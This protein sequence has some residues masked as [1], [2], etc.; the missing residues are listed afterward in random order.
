MKTYGVMDIVYIHVLLTSA[1]VG[2]EWSA[3]RPG[4][5]NSGKRVYS[6]HWIRRWVDPRAGLHDVEKRKFLTLQGLEMRLLSRRARSQ[7]LYRLS[8]PGSLL[9]TD[10][11]LILVTTQMT[12]S[13]LSRKASNRE[14]S[15][16]GCNAVWFGT[17]NPALQMQFVDVT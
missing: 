6:T 12:S 7:S 13:V 4:R 10:T 16:L 9:T 1:L 14:N 5:S 3:S 2:D 11:I 17:S 8:Y 15:A